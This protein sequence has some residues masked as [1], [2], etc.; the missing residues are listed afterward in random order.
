MIKAK[1][2]FV[3]FLD[4]VKNELVGKDI[5]LEISKVDQL[6]SFQA[7]IAA[8]E[9]IIPVIGAFSSGKSF[10]INTFLGSS[11]LPVGITPETAL[12]TELRYSQKE[13]IE[14]V[15]K[16][17]ECDVY[18]ITDMN[19]VTTK[20]SEYTYIR[21]FLNNENLKNIMPLVLVDMPGF[22]SPLDS[23]NKAL[24]EYINKGTHY[25]VLTSVE[26]G[27]ITRPM[28]RQL[29]DISEF[30]RD[31]TFFLSKINLKASTEVEEIK[32]K[33]EEQIEDYLDIKKEAIGIDND[34]GKSF[35]VILEN[36][37]YEELFESLFKTELKTITFSVIENLN[38]A[39]SAL[40]RDTR[41]NEQIIS[42]L[43]NGLERLIKQRENLI[44]D[45]KQKYSD[46]GSERVVQTV[47]MELSNSIEELVRA[48]IYGGSDSMSHLLSE[49]IRNSLLS[50]TKMAFGE[51]SDNVINSFTTVLSDMKGSALS[52][53]NEQWLNKLTGTMKTVFNSAQSGLGSII[54]ERR[55]HTDATKMYKTITTVLAVTTSVVTPFLE[56]VIIFLPEI[57]NGLFSSIQ[58][59]KQEEQ[60]RES[61][62]TQVIP[63]IKT[64][65]RSKIPPLFQ[66]Q[67]ATLIDD[68]SQQF[69]A[70]LQEKKDAIEF[71]EKERLS[72]LAENEEKI[73]Q[74]MNIIKNLT[75][76]TNNVLYNQ[77]DMINVCA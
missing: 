49:I 36:I 22:N 16:N 74:Y 14:A 69:E 3:N 5:P 70:K 52:L 45:A 26:D 32:A 53:D 7:T 18:E 15:K 28:V 64:N 11:Y 76:H 50:T 73:E 21:L 38:T 46:S 17:G 24:M 44:S 54:S 68:I 20:A 48:A 66:E 41:E 55:N 6:E 23:H 59:K 30:G 57:V 58:K 31:F 61:I 9:L 25:I 42:E 47:G 56:V 37:D 75:S 10:F 40:K 71:A 43:K 35:K 8:K 2:K 72:K 13:I 27:N 39:V 33:I 19:L 29:S 51:I 1:E 4:S 77:E 65:I 62:M 34:S 60:V 12:A 67:V 63:S